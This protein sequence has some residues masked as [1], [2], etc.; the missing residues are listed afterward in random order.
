MNSIRIALPSDI[1]ECI[2]IRGKTRENAVSRSRLEELGITEASWAAQ[3][4]C[5]ELIGYI[6]QS[7]RKMVGYCFGSTITGEIVVLA[8]LPE[9]ENQGAGKA[10]LQRVMEAL[11]QQGHDRLFLGCADDPGVRSYGFYRYLGWS[12]TG[13]RDA[14][15]DEELEY[16]F[17]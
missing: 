14:H 8:I 4:Q 3:L 9:C 13:E 7:N 16:K 10:L 12:P 11:K 5:G 17:L 6:W 1:N 2:N 15:G